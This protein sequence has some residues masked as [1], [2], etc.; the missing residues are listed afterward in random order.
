[1]RWMVLNIELA[2]LSNNGSFSAAGH[3]STGGGYGISVG[4]LGVGVT[5]SGLPLV[6]SSGWGLTDD[7][8]TRALQLKSL[9]TLTAGAVAGFY[10]STVEVLR[11]HNDGSIVSSRGATSGDVVVKVGTTLADASVNAGTKLFSVSTG[12]GGTEIEKAHIRKSGSLVA[13]SN[14]IVF[15]DANDLNGIGSGVKYNSMS[16]VIGLYNA[17]NTSLLGLNTT[18]GVAFSSGDFIAGGVLR[19]SNNTSGGLLNQDAGQSRLDAPNNTTMAVTSSNGAYSTD[20]VVKIGS[21]VSDASVHANAKLLSISTGISG[22]KTEKSHIR[23][24]GAYVANNAGGSGNHLTFGSASDLYNIGAG[25]KY[26]Q[27]TAT[28]G[29][30][31]S[32][33]AAY[34]GLG[35]GDG[36]ARSTGT[37][38]AGGTLQWS[39]NSTGGIFTQNSGQSRL[40]APNNATMAISSSL[41]ADRDDIVVKVG[42]TEVDADV[43]VESKLLSVRTR[44]GSYEKEKAAIRGSGRIDQAG[45][46][47]SGTPGDATINKPIGKSAIASGATS[48]TINNSLVSPGDLVFITWLGDLGTQ[49]RTPWVEVADEKFIVRVWNAPSTAVPFCWEVKRL[50]VDT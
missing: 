48:V 14:N 46:D 12:I 28:I 21:R 50:I 17:S 9:T 31:S 18:N 30:Y 25:V 26:D 35:L 1:M 10:N 16:T 43:N 36:V 11:V 20:V 6:L 39:G 4:A 49:S 23:A 8:S 33:N 34:L 19:W 32:N 40:D 38:R 22:A 44:I 42:T 13:T 7:T 45:A 29:L 2:S 3:V 24:S 27:S 47:S 37:F 41:G 5:A 15:G